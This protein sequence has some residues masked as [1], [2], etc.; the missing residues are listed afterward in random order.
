MENR[1]EDNDEI[2]LLDYLKI[3]A[4][5]K[6]LII[7]LICISVTITSII[8][9]QM[10][11]IYEAKALITPA[12]QP[13][14]QGGINVIAAQFGIA[15]PASSNA[16]EIVNILKSNI[17]R[18]KIIKKYD[19]LPV[20]FKKEALEGKTEEQKIWTGIRY[21]QSTLGISFNQKDNVVEVSMQFTDPKKAADIVNYTLTE[22]TEYMS[23]EAKRIADTNKKYLESLIDN[24]SDPLIRT[25][26]YSLIAQQIE[27]S[28][29]AEVKENFAF[30][31][32]DPPR[33][34]D[35]KI[36]P[37]RRANVMLSFVVSLFAG[38]F[39][40]FFRE[41]VDVVRMREK[42]ERK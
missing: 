26:I 31:I 32:I 25:K 20:F 5:N 22:L 42:R 11:E 15:S 41:Y 13:R 10:P 8:S 3:I 16:S 35:R 23:S 38:I 24:I 6:L 2:N 36:K 33:A 28:M 7:I 12:V 1:E 39:I 9:F 19:L 34:P 14:D 4:K 29:M 27:T 40:A 30:K 17:L 37:K 21:L 18:E